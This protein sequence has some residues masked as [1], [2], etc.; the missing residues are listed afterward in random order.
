MEA[1]VET[2]FHDLESRD[3]EAVK[4]K[5][6]QAVKKGAKKVKTDVGL[7]QQPILLEP[8]PYPY[9]WPHGD[10][11]HRLLHAIEHAEKAVLHAVE[12]EVNGLFHELEHHEHKEA[13]T[14]GVAKAQIRLDDAHESRR[15]WFQDRDVRETIVM[16]HCWW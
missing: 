1:E 4:E 13:L 15:S 10:P 9:D 16:D 12:A 6:Q 8:H 5:A 2:L 7:K 3:K 11:E 14:K